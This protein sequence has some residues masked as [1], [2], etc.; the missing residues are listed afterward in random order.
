MSV[1]EAGVGHDGFSRY[2]RRRGSRRHDR[3]GGERRGR[4]DRRRRCRGGT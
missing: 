1:D 3:R 4:L 2:Y